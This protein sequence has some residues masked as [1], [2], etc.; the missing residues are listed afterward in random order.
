MGAG[1]RSPGF[2]TGR[3][4]SIRLYSCSSSPLPP[5][6][7][8]CGLVPPEMTCARAEKQ[9]MQGA[10]SVLSVWVN[11]VPYALYAG[12]SGERQGR[13]DGN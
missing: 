12:G 13:K 8:E 10:K 11:N 3:G 6:D 5:R 1:R 2:S 7:G 9:A 4:V